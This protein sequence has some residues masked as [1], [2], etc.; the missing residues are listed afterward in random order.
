MQVYFLPETVVVTPALEHLEPALTAAWAGETPSNEI[1]RSR[2][3]NLR[4]SQYYFETTTLITRVAAERVSV[5]AN[6]Q[7]IDQVPTSSIFTVARVKIPPVRSSETTVS[8]AQTVGVVDTALIRCPILNN[9]EFWPL[10]NNSD[11]VK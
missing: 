11:D 10:V 7:L 5:P 1:A 6:P 4:I 9:P 2:T 8:T 3:I